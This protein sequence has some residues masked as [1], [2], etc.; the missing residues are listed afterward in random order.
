M[1]ENLSPATWTVAYRNPR[2]NRFL[3]VAL[4]L[5]WHEARDLAAKLCETDPK[6]QVYYVTS[7]AHEAREAVNL[8]REVAAGRLSQDAADSYTEDH[9]NVLVDTGRRVRIFEGGT[10]PAAVAEWLDRQRYAN[11]VGDLTAA[12]AEIPQ[13]ARDA[14]DRGEHARALAFLRDDVR[15]ALTPAAPALRWTGRSADGLRAFDVAPGWS[16]EIHRA[17]S[18]VTGKG[19][20][21]YARSIHF[22]VGI[23]LIAS[24]NLLRDAKTAGAEWAARARADHAESVR[25]RTEGTDAP[26]Y[27]A[28]TAR[29]NWAANCLKGH[30]EQALA[31]AEDAAHEIN[32]TR[33][34][35]RDARDAYAHA[36]YLT[37]LTPAELAAGY[38]DWDTGS[39]TL[40]EQTDAYATGRARRRA[41]DRLTALA[42][43]GRTPPAAAL[44]S[45]A[46]GE[47]DRA[48]AW[49]REDVMA[50]LRTAEIVAHAEL[51]DRNW[52]AIQADRAHRARMIELGRRTAAADAEREARRDADTVGWDITDLGR[53]ALKSVTGFVAVDARPLCLRVDGAHVGHMAAVDNE[54]RTGA[55]PHADAYD[56]DAEA[57]GHH[58]HGYA[59][60][61]N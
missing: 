19:Y 36:G 13:A 23:M 20:A 16:L 47:F 22:G 56:A 8:P 53:A 37:G 44:D 57:W 1:A 4:E 30:R 17:D 51:A 31:A 40:A 15:D 21:V 18:A 48:T 54:C 28:T 2:A 5:T 27:D 35:D 29:G 6:L 55:G 38:A 59:S 11:R 24:R 39:Y 41:L 52:A 43:A 46:R 9:G 49:M 7:A 10:L 33:Q 58:G 26:T 12:G 45:Y 25:A 61:P 34:D 60:L 3:R 14:A 50:D 32:H 42:D